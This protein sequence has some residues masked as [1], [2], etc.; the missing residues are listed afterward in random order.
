MD[1]ALPDG[2]VL[3]ELSAGTVQLL[4]ARARLVGQNLDDYLRQLAQPSEPLRAGVCRSMFDLIGQAPPR[5]RQ[6]IDS[7]TQDEKESWGEP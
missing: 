2:K 3:L 7:Q 6:D 1:S 4:E 5:S